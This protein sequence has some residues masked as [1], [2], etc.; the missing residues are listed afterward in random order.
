[1]KFIDRKKELRVLNDARKASKKRL[2]SVLITGPRRVGK[3]R[4]VLETLKKSDLYFF[5]NDKKTSASLLS[6]Y[7]GYLKSRGLLGNLESVRTWDEFFD[8]LFKRFSGVVAFD[9]FQNFSEVDSSVFGILQKFIDLNENR[10]NLFFIY[11]GSVAGL[12]KKLFSD[13]KEPLYGRVKRTLHLKEMPF[14]GVMDMCREAGVNDIEE[15]IKLY[16]IFG[17]FPKYYVSM[18]DEP[19]EKPNAE[20]I[21]D[22]FFFSENA[23]LEDEVMQIL[24]LEFGRRSGTYYDILAG[25]AKGNT[26]ISELASFLGKKETALTRQINE[27]SNYFEIIGTERSVVGKKSTYY[28]RHPL[29]NFWFR[30]FHKNISAYKRKETWLIEKVRR[31][32]N[33]YVGRRFEFLCREFLEE[34]GSGILP[35]KP[36]KIGRWWGHR[37]VD[38]ERKEMEID[39]VALNEKTNDI[40]FAECKWQDKVNPNKILSDLKE[41]AQ[42]VDWNKEKRKEHYAIFAKSFSTRKTQDNVILIGL[43]DIGKIISGN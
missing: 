42:Y 40:L 43:K 36:E 12:L 10:K 24:S 6:E 11:C 4:L 32:F 5:V 34:N 8:V 2:Y 37:R 31:N 20:K 9:E 23:I 41:K 33:S 27:L 15:M 29:I 16:A 1:M 19:I 22:A 25:I 17:G 3:T 28:I 30:F 13:S 35:F 18:E 39:I 7:E 14:T 26:R 21:L 38:G